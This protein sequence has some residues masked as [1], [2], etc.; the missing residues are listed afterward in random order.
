MSTASAALIGGGTIRLKIEWVNW[1]GADV[2]PDDQTLTIIDSHANVVATI[3]STQLTKDATGQ[4][5]YDYTAP[6][7]VANDTFCAQWT[8]TIA[9]ESD[10]RRYFFEVEA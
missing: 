10:V 9:G 5:H 4:Y 2:D 6:T 3:E 1:A 7:M 8:A